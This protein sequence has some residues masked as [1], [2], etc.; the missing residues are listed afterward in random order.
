MGFVHNRASTCDFI[1]TAFLMSGLPRALVVAGV[2][3]QSCPIPAAITLGLGKD[4]EGEGGEGGC[5][6]GRCIGAS[7]GYT[8][9]SWTIKGLKRM[10]RPRSGMMDVDILNSYHVVTCMAIV[11]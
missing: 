1:L 10:P 2:R 3:A 6:A 4:T 9:S 5:N 11:P 8:R 7:S